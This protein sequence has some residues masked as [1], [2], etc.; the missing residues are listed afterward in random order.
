VTVV[1]HD[2]AEWVLLEPTDN[3]FSPSGCKWLPGRTGAFSLRCA[4]LSWR[5]SPPSLALAGVDREG[6]V[7]AAEFYTDGHSL[8][9]VG[10]RVASTN[11]GYVA[12]AHAGSNLVVAV[13]S[14]G[15]DWL[16]VRGDRFRLAHKV[17]LGIP[18]AV[19]VFA[20]H[21]RDALVVCSRGLVMRVVPPRRGA[22]TK[23]HGGAERDT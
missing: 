2:Q 11:V 1:T 5:H 3:W 14:M 20:T 17:E 7:R 16:S 4:P 15:V 21:S 19:A 12:A 10:S 6:A 9:L 23:K 8:Q 18:T 13:S 22:M